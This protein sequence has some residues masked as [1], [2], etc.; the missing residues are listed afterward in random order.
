MVRFLTSFAHSFWPDIL[1]AHAFP[2]LL[3]LRCSFAYEFPILLPCRSGSMVLLPK[4][5]QYFC[6]AL[7]LWCWFRLC[8]GAIRS[9]CLLSYE[10]PIMLP[11]RLSF[12]YECPILLPRR[13]GAMAPRWTPKEF[14]R[15][16]RVICRIQ[17]HATAFW[18]E[19][20][21]TNIGLLRILELLK[22]S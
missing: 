11:L 3:S 22:N 18:K 6:P 2:I 5:F 19:S 13:S 8:S 16:F 15:N 7:G 10:F 14:L 17:K 21:E 9:R 12:A 20:K 1:C 4:N